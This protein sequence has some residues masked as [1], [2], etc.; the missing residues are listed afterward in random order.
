M[1]TPGGF[2]CQPD[3]HHQPTSYELFA[4]RRENNLLRLSQSLIKYL[5]TFEKKTVCALQIVVE[6]RVE[7]IKN[8]LRTGIFCVCLFDKRY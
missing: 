5:S 7:R 4:R 1:L 3:S 2:D 6:C 8:S